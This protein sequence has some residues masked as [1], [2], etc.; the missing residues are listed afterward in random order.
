MKSKPVVGGSNFCAITYRE[1]KCRQPESLPGRLCT[2]EPF[3]KKP[4]IEINN[5]P[6][7]H[8]C[9]VL[10]PAGAWL[11][12]QLRNSGLS[13]LLILCKDFIQALHFLNLSLL[14]LTDV[15]LQLDNSQ[16][17]AA[18]CRAFCEV[19]E[20]IWNLT[21]HCLSHDM[22]L[23]RA[24]SNLHS[25]TAVCFNSQ[26]AVWSRSTVDGWME[27]SPS[28]SALH[29]PMPCVAVVSSSLREHRILYA[30]QQIHLKEH[31]LRG[32]HFF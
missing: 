13:A 19:R 18:V 14:C 5:V 3:Q 4:Q 22:H 16:H 17:W 1:R 9:L 27:G 25:G 29:C 26:V 2:A 21:N 11:L 12:I 31:S 32:W 28:L 7:P 20:W 24:K 23:Q 8:L 30:C 15:H 10:C 6:F